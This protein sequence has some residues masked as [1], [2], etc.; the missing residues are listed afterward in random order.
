MP[1]PLP[2]P[3]AGTG[4]VPPPRNRDLT[5]LL[6]A[7][8]QVM[9]WTVAVEGLRVPGTDAADTLRRRP[10]S[11]VSVV[12]IGF[13]A[14]QLPA[15]PGGP[16]V[17]V[18]ELD[19]RLYCGDLVVPSF[20]TGSGARTLLVRPDTAEEVSRVRGWPMIGVGGELVVPPSPGMRWEIPP[21]DPARRAP[22][23]FPDAALVARDSPPP[24]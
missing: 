13:E 2:P 5:A 21:W 4:A 20:V 16:P 17:P 3:L 10:D 24:P 1:F 7:Y 23:A 9:G 22:L 18:L 15:R 14:L 19:D 6:T 8:E 12:C 11:M